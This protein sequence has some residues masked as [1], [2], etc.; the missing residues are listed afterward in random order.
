M[1]FFAIVCIVFHSFCL[2]LAEESAFRYGDIYRLPFFVLW[3]G[4]K[5]S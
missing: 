1:L 4:L 2:D 5:G 3:G